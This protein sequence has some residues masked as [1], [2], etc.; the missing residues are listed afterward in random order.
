MTEEVPTTTIEENQRGRIE[1]LE[2]ILQRIYEQLE[3]GSII[4]A[5]TD[6]HIEIAVACGCKD[7]DILE[8]MKL[9][10]EAKERNE[11]VG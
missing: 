3:E 5:G 8:Q 4:C 6:L 7:K 9:I 2:D 1:C 11:V 10:N